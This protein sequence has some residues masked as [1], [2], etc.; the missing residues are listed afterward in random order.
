MMAPVAVIEAPLDPPRLRAEATDPG[1]GAI[2]VFEG[3]ARDH[4]AGLDVEGL[5]YEAY[6]PM[7]VAELERLR[8]EALERFSLLRCLIHHRIG[9]VPLTE[10]AVVVVTAS[11]H[12]KEAFEAALWIMDR[13]KACVPIWKR[14]RYAEGRE[15]WV[16]GEGRRSKT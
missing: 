14:E 5:A 9:P 4:H 12:R 2:V 3:C 11:V 7:A 10:A 16:E 15:A 8:A 6:V 1:A 13:I